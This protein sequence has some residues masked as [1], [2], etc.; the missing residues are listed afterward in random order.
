MRYERLSK[1]EQMLFEVFQEVNAMTYEQVKQFLMKFTGCSENV[2]KYIVHNLIR[3]GAISPTQEDEEGILLCGNNRNQNIQTARNDVMFAMYYLLDKAETLD[4]MLSLATS[5]L[6]NV[7]LSFI[8]D[9]KLYEAIKVSDKSLS[10]IETTKQRYIERFAENNKQAIPFYSVFM[11][12]VHAGTE[13]EAE[14]LEELETMNIE[15]PHRIVIFRS[16]DPTTKPDYVEYA[17]E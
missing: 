5:Y 10:L 11:F 15:I 4:D 8:L 3:Q 17:I 9:G 6:N 12:T 2:P 7:A 1:Q 16:T 13:E 14:I